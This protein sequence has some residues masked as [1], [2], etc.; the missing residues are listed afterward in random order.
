MFRRQFLQRSLCTL[1]PAISVPSCVYST[2]TTDEVRGD[3]SDGEPL[4]QDLGAPNLNQAIA[5]LLIFGFSGKSA[6][7]QDVQRVISDIENKRCGGVILLSRNIWSFDQMKALCLEISNAS[8]SGDP[9]IAI[10]NEGGAV[11]RTSAATGF[12][13]WISAEQA[14]ASFTGFNQAYE[15]Y[16]RRAVE[17]HLVGVNLNLAPVVDVNTFRENPIIGALGRSY[18]SDPHEV[19]RLASDFVVAHRD[20]QVLTSI[21]HFP[22]HG[23]SRVDSHFEIPDISASWDDDELIPFRSMINRG[24]TDTIMTGHL[25]HPRF[26]DSEGYPASLSRQT[27]SFIRNELRFDGVVVTDDLMMAPIEEIHSI[28]QAATSALKAG[29]D[30]LIFSA[31]REVDPL[32]PGRVHASIKQALAEGQL[33]ENAIYSSARRVRSLKRSLSSTTP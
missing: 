21:K 1:C 30:L 25:Y 32:L 14:H 26:S 13:S 33:D 19:A 23:S 29:A 18:S 7:D 15:Y 27:Y 11:L 28:E 16:L 8:L 6:S 22:G 24:L 9:L 31:F 3:S 20:A 10:D 2:P 17:L 4:A 5:D 12:R